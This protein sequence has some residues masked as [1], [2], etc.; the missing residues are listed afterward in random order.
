MNR[1]SLHYNSG[2][3]VPWQL[4]FRHEEG[5]DCKWGSY[6]DAVGIFCKVPKSSTL[7]KIIPDVST[8]TFTIS[9]SVEYTTIMRYHKLCHVLSLYSEMQ[10]CQ[11]EDIKPEVECIFNLTTIYGS[12]GLEDKI[13]PQKFNRL[14][15][16][17]VEF[18]TIYC[19]AF[20]APGKTRYKYSTTNSKRRF[21]QYRKHCYTVVADK[22]LIV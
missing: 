8:N 3:I 20:M 7:K 13:S 5:N 1:K 14:S 10:T 11:G 21:P 18:C 6:V 22:D 4:T 16:E 9:T 19:L 17:C 15:S 2:K 12:E